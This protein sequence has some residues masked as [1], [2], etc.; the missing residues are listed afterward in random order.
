[1]I[2][3]HSAHFLINRSIATTKFEPTYARRAFPCFDEP[4][5]KAKFSIKLVHPMNDCYSA[6]SNMDVKV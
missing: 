3:M 6:L 5:F 4:D 2:I 1:M